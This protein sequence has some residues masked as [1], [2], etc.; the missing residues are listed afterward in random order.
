[1]AEQLFEE[2][3]FVAEIRQLHSVKT[4]EQ[5]PF[6]SPYEQRHMKQVECT[7]SDTQLYDL[8]SGVIDRLNSQPTHHQTDIQF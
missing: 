6:V 7:L 3:P 4:G 2:E 1:M 5:Y 8:M